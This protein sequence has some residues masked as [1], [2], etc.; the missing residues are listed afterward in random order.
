VGTNIT[1]SWW[2]DWNATLNGAISGVSAERMNV[3]ETSA[4]PVPNGNPSQN[5][6]ATLRCAPLDPT[7]NANVEAAHSGLINFLVPTC[8][9]CINAVFGPLNTSQAEFESFLTQG[10]EFCD[11]TT[12]QE[13]G[14]TI[15]AQED[16]VAAYIQKHM[17]IPDL[18]AAVTAKGEKV[19]FSALFG[20]VSYSSDARKNLKVFFVPANMAGKTLADNESTDFHEALHG[21]TNLGD[22]GAPALTGFG[23][24]DALG[25]TPQTKIAVIYPDCWSQTSR[26]TQ[27][28]E[29][30]IISA[31]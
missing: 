15:G 1:Y 6:K 13:P 21:F 22:G 8:T 2:R 9:F 30:N 31:H 12:S 7:T 26:I 29:Q 28:I 18:V 19:K 16:T 24:C 25:A 5:G 17:G 11:G 27:W 23:L 3:A 20:L 14:A 10:H 4:S